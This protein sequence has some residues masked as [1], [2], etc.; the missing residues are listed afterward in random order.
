MTFFKAEGPKTFQ[1][2]TAGL[3]DSSQARVKFFHSSAHSLFCTTRATL[4]SEQV[5]IVAAAKFF[6]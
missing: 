1:T 6:F 5:S 2:S 3:A 4:S